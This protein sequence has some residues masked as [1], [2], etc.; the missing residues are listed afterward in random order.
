MDR[1][2]TIYIINL[3]VL[4]VT[5]DIWVVI[6]FVCKTLQLWSVFAV[7]VD[8]VRSVKWGYPALLRHQ[9]SACNVVTSVFWVVK[10]FTVMR[11]DIMRGSWIGHIVHRNCLLRHVIEGNIT[12]MGRL[13]GRR[14][15]LLG[16]VKE[17][18]DTGNR[19]WK[20]Y[21]SLWLEIAEEEWT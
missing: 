14:K 11:M 6:T 4:F 2:K 7:N 3:S 10:L 15:Q 8:N 9:C 20:H 13:G 5:D 16:D 12:V 19:K 21:T 1:T 18:E 17:R